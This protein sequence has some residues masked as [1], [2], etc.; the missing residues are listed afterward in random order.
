MSQYDF[1]GKIVEGKGNFDV[2]TQYINLDGK[3]SEV[4]IDA[5]MAEYPV[6]GRNFLIPSV[7]SGAFI[8]QQYL[9]LVDEYD[10]ICANN[11]GSRLSIEIGDEETVLIG[12]KKFFSANGVYNVSG[13]EVY[14]KPD[15]MIEMTAALDGG[16]IKVVGEEGYRISFDLNVSECNVGEA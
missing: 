11:R 5:R 14:T 8:E 7:Q 3:H 2:Y 12:A 9:A 13:M 4:A 10:Q 1:L 6:T 15:S 16:V